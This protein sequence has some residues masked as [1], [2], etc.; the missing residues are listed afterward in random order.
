[1]IKNSLLVIFIIIILIGVS[2]CMSK[3]KEP[4]VK[5]QVE[6]YMKDKYNEEF[7]V[8]G[9]G[10]EGWNDSDE[11]IYVSSEKFPNARIMIKR[12]KKSGEMIDNYMDFLMKS[13]IEDLLN[14]IASKVYPKSK[15]F[16]STDESPLDGTSMQ[17]ST[18]EYI[19]Y[20]AKS[21]HLS[22]TICVSDPEYKVNKNDKLEQLRLG[23]EEKQ[24]N[25]T[26]SIIYVPDDK[27]AQVSESNLHDV[28]N[29]YG[30]FTNW[31]LS[32]GVFYMDRTTYKLRS[33]DWEEAK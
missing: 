20:C 2:G 29:R 12:G 4:T 14:G 19:R 26:F 15:V 30:D 9:G 7:K 11:E 5:E 33:V 22:L 3:T 13:K 21:F 25:P 28:E 8:L 18:D 16:Y 23:F 27:F 31:V 10:T 6:K 32:K 17:M 24:Y 1:M